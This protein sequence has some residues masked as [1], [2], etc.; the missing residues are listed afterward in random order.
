MLKVGNGPMLPTSR[1]IHQLPVRSIVAKPGNSDELA[2]GVEGFNGGG[3]YT[4]VD[5]GQNWKLEPSI[6]TGVRQVQF[7]PDG[8]LYALTD[9]PTS[10]GGQ[11]LHRRNPD[12]SWSGL[13]PGQPNRYELFMSAMCIDPENP[14][15]VL[16]A[17]SDY[18][19][20]QDQASIWRSTSGGGSWEQVVVASA[21]R[22]TDLAIAGSGSSSSYLAAV[23]DWRDDK[24]FEV[25]RSSDLG[26]TWT[27]VLP[28]VRGSFRV[29]IAF[30]VSRQNPDRVYLSRY[31]GSTALTRSDD[32]G[33]TWTETGAYGHLSKIVVDPHDDQVL[34]AVGSL[35]NSPAPIM[36]LR[37][38]GNTFEDFSQ[39]FP[40]GEAYSLFLIDGECPSLMVGGRRSVAVR[41]AEARRPHLA[42]RAD[43]AELWPP[44]HELVE[45]H[46][47]VSVSDECDPAPQWALASIQVDDDR[48]T[49]PRDIAGAEFGTADNTFFLRAARAGSGEGR[50]YHITYAAVD[51]SGNVE[52]R[53]I[54]V[55]APHDQSG[56]KVTKA[57]DAGRS[58]ANEVT[59]LPQAITST[60][61]TEIRFG[62]SHPERV[63]VEVFDLSGA[64]VRTVADAIRSA[65]AQTVA[66][67]GRDSG[68]RAV[69]SGVYLVR[70]AAPSLNW[71]GKA[72]L[73]K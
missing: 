35:L 55:S 68:G 20:G 42:V 3:V 47:T 38:G 65:G 34:Y 40:S 49:P 15:L 13:G 32:A 73:V 26:R 12:G 18:R 14:G 48:P 11:G 24:Q 62:L 53:T 54:E 6:R 28:A 5:G 57:A 33:Q 22:V 72:V 69:P 10:I 39:G 56:R 17:G 36:R 50:T 52:R 58:A 25:L 70:V 4:S 63:R 29:P 59:Q 51:A 21:G 1:G 2:A 71:S 66:W 61:G 9:G 60:G 27:G 37:D 64:R 44:N 41:P 8:L 7:G 19:T 16:V 46:T 45:V 43:H 67:D 30:A 31:F 23:H